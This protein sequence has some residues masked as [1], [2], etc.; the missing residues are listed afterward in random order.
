VSVAG[1]D[2]EKDLVDGV[3]AIVEIVVAVYNVRT[4]ST[5]DPEIHR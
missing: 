5:L 4:G 2:W 1:V 3:V